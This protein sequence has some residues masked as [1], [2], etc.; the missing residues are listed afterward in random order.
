MPLVAGPTTGN[1]YYVRSASEI[2]VVTEPERKFATISVAV[3]AGADGNKDP[4]AAL[5]RTTSRLFIAA[6]PGASR[7]VAVID[8]R[9]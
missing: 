7:V 9:R 8:D 1:V 3:L 2:T 4:Q 5:N 6:D